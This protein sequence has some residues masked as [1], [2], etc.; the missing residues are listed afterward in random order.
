MEMP[1]FVIKALI[2]MEAFAYFVLMDKFGIKLLRHVYVRT[3]M[4]G[5]ETSVNIN[6]TAQVQEFTILNIKF[7]FAPMDKP[8]MVP[9]VLQNKNVVVEN[10]G[11]IQVFNVIAQLLSTGMVELVFSVQVEKY[12]TQLQDH[13]FV[14]LVL[15]GMVNSAHLFKAVKV[16]QSGTK[17]LGLV[18]V[19]QQLFGTTCIVWLIL[20][21]E[22]KFG[23]MLQKL[24]SVQEI[25]S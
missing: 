13:V 3:I 19:L 8:G 7:V 2:G 18:N 15:N 25:K 14:K 6:K 24:V 16:D 9:P 20:A 10:N 5:T 22:V 23:I 4:S 1:V 21:M 12:G 11:M 17:T